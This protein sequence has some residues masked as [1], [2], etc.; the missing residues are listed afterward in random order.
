MLSFD[1]FNDLTQNSL[2]NRE[3]YMDHQP[4]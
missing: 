1:K 4:T 2:P 3:K